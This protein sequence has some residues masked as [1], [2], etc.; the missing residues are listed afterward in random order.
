MT[1][2][3]KENQA[4]A[5]AQ[6]AG[7]AF[8]DQR[9]SVSEREAAATD[10]SDVTVGQASWSGPAPVTWPSPGST[11]GAPAAVSPEPSSSPNVADPRDNRQSQ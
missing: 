6:S 2:E 3:A 5:A 9:A 1:A 4:A 11:S 7:E 10:G 8:A